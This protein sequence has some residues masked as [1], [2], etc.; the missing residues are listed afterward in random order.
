M[1][2]KHHTQKRFVIYY[3]ADR[4]KNPCF[5]ETLP[6]PR[7]IELT[8]NVSTTDKVKRSIIIH[9]HFY[10]LDFLLL[11]MSKILYNNNPIYFFLIQNRCKKVNIHICLKMEI[12][13]K[14]PTIL[15]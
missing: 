9:T 14:I 4:W 6:E 10:I 5:S 2:N 12:L 15:F 8:T 7:S 1:E 13:H 3:S 11:F